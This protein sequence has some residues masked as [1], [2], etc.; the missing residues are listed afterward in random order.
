MAE[1]PVL[2]RYAGDALRH[3]AMPVGGVGTGSISLGGRGQLTDRELF[4]RPAKGYAPD[5]FFCLRVD[6][7]EGSH[8]RALEIALLDLEYEGPSG[9]STPLHGLPRFRTGEFAAAYPFGQ[10][11]MS[12]PEVPVVATV[13]AFN[14][15][16]PGDASGIP[17]LVY[18]VHLENTSNSPVVV[19]VVGNLQH[20]VGRVPGR[21]LPSGNVFRRPEGD[22]PSM[23]LGHSTQVPEEDEA[24]GTWPSPS[25]ATRSAAHGSPGP[26]GP[27]ATPCSSS[28][29]TS[30]PTESSTSRRSAPACRP[31]PSS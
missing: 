25:S 10:V 6:G 15:L 24:W 8:T 3:I 20:I 5:S 21:E 7:P 4:N 19:H 31:A 2:R 11:R 28:G 23:L 12:D 30:A 29:R 13:G 18:R 22:G 16:V 26:G 9:S 1:W 27:G 14:P 17:A